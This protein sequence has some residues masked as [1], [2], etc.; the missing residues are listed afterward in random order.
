VFESLTHASIATRADGQP[1]VRIPLEQLAT[2]VLEV[3]KI[4]DMQKPVD[5]LVYVLSLPEVGWRT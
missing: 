3:D 5:D 1:I 2:G 4:S